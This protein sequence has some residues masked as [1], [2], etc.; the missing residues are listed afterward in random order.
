[1]VEDDAPMDIVLIGGVSGSGKNVALA[2]L[3]GVLATSAGTGPGT[4]HAAAPSALAASERACTSE[5]VTK[6]L[7]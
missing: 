3:A 1:M 4:P 6:E 5:S 2:A 7:S